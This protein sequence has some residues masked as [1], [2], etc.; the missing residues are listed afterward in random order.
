M[1]L[2][3]ETKGKLEYQKGELN[4]MLECSKKPITKDCRHHLQE[5]ID[6][7]KKR[8]SYYSSILETLNNNTEWELGTNGDKYF[9][10]LQKDNVNISIDIS[11][12]EASRIEKNFG[13][14][15]VEYPF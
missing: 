5:E 11:K 6:K 14:K 4:E 2:I 10:F 9:L 1:N 3:T 8:I 13:V 7:T 12:I 15:A